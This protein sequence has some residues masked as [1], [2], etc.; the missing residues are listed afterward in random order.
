MQERYIITGDA[1]LEPTMSGTASARLHF[2]LQPLAHDLQRATGCY[3]RHVGMWRFFRVSRSLT[4]F[5][6]AMRHSIGCTLSTSHG[7][8]CCHR[9]DTSR[10]PNQG[11]DFSDHY[12][13]VAGGYTAAKIVPLDVKSHPEPMSARTIPKLDRRQPELNPHSLPQCSTFRLLK[14]REHGRSCA[15]SLTNKTRCT[16][17][18]FPS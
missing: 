12:L 18:K 6:V 11:S 4:D 8:I 17:L 14:K 7:P 2:R 5:V 13:H 16:E 1:I 10:A 15:L 3:V 9:Q